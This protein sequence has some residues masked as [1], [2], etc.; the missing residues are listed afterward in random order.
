MN[1]ENL[2]ISE[3]FNLLDEKQNQIEMIIDYL[4][5]KD[6]ELHELVNLKHLSDFDREHYKSRQIQIIVD[7]VNIKQI[8]K[9]I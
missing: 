8:L 9:M 4:E 2:K 5:K 3:L 7:K 6:Y 1:Y